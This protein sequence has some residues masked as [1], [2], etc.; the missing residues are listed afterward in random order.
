M[1][2]YVT[3]KDYYGHKI[4]VKVSFE[5]HQVYDEAEKAKERERYERRKHLDER[6]LEDFFGSE[7]AAS[8][9]LE[10]FYFNHEN[11]RAV[12]EILQ[13]CT[14]IQRK[15]FYLNRIC[16]YSFAEI[17]RMEGRHKSTVEDSV[18]L[19]LKKINNF[20]GYTPDN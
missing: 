13:K 10:D 11:L 5:I 14:P 3:I 6:S 16:G 19:V 2:Y 8:G 17:A 4:T 20:F 9:T 18:K 1:S 12:F 15:R 7:Q